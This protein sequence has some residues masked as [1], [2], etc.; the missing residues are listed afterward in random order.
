MIFL[1]TLHEFNIS[2]LSSILIVCFSK[3]NIICT[4]FMVLVCFLFINKH[5]SLCS[6][7]NKLL[8][9]FVDRRFLLFKVFSIQRSVEILSLAKNSFRLMLHSTRT[10]MHIV[11]VHDEFSLFKTMCFV[12][13]WHE[14]TSLNSC[15]LKRKRY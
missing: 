3:K 11:V 2:K 9:L 7:V 15:F 10:I 4:V 5:F 14:S 13:G 12:F 6:L 1:L 8:S